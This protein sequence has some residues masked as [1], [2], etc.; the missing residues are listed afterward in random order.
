MIAF[1]VNAIYIYV[2]VYI[3]TD[4]LKRGHHHVYLKLSL[5]DK[6]NHNKILLNNDQNY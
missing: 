6:F 2:C 3:Y 1:R 4:I 5:V